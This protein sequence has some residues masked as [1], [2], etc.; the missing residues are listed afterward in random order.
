MHCYL[1]PYFEKR[2]SI[3]VLLG[4]KKCF[5][6]KDGFIHNNPG[7]IVIIGGGGN[8][9]SRDAKI[10]SALREFQ[11]ETGHRL[12]Y[13]KVRHVMEPMGKKYS[14]SFY[15]VDT[16]QEY[17]KLKQLNAE[18]K[19]KEIVKVQW[20]P[21]KNAAH[22][23]SNYLNN[24]PCYGK[25]SQCIHDYIS[26]LNVWKE[27][28]EIQNMAEFGG[29]QKFLF[30]HHQFTKVS[31]PEIFGSVVNEQRNSRFYSQIYSYLEQYIQKRSYIDWFSSGINNLKQI[32]ENKTRSSPKKHGTSQK[33]SQKSYNN[34]ARNM[35]KRHGNQKDCRK[36]F[37]QRNYRPSKESNNNKNRYY[38]SSSSRSYNS[39]SNRSHNSDSNR[40]YNSSSSRSYNSSSGRYYNSSSSRFPNSQSSRFSND[41]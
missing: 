5:S 41:L 11:E 24:Q 19:F 17:M 3:E 1:L 21:I 18:D 28:R 9:G 29:F 4:T 7:Q 31:L 34:R 6:N 15:K 16:K 36:N 30:K 38:T 25:M 12:N 40:C 35:N 20:F 13:S 10:Y 14:I 33:I 2:N 39:S 27:V 26:R 23:F 8:G 22:I 32:C 37:K